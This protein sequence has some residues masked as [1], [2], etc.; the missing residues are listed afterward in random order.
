M[1]LE[2]ANPPG[3][4]QALKRRDEIAR[5]GIEEGDHVDFG[6]RICRVAAIT[7]NQHLHLV[8]DIDGREVDVGQVSPF[9]V[10]K[11]EGD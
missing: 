11:I 4:R 1:S 10:T 7:P 3:G 8:E 9:L 5:Q 6:G 2:S